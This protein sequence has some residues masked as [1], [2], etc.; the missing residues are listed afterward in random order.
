L[1]LAIGVD[2]G[3]TKIA[4]GAVSNDGAVLSR[5]DVPTPSSD[6]SALDDAICQAVLRVAEGAAVD[7][8]GIGAA[9]WI[10]LESGMIHFSPHIAWRDY[11]VAE[12]VSQRLQVP[13]ILRNDADAAG[14]AEY[15]FGA[16]RGAKVALCVTVGTGIGGGIIIDGEL[17]RGN[18]GL[19]G[20]IGHMVIRQGG[21]KCA[22]GGVGCWETYASGSALVAQAR[23]WMKSK[24]TASGRLVELCGDRAG[25]LTG[26]MITR[27]AN[28]GDALAAE[29]FEWL[30]RRLGTGL[31]SL[32][33][34]L[35]PSVIVVG[36]GVSD[37]G[38]LLLS[39][40]RA[41]FANSMTNAP[42][43]PP[44]VRAE[45]GT[46]AGMVGAADLA[47]RELSGGAQTQRT[48]S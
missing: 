34:V 48:P 12:H 33:A 44:I 37:A 32:A 23:K 35:D 13:V 45:L 39:P 25:D 10:G 26:S 20:E 6:A 2:I 41:S 43:R 8:V 29:L 27:A 16:A 19:A 42:S 11:P 31:G 9:G 15:R 5:H 47:S 14:W 1:G 3:G 28:E 38:E 18:A 7:V 40:A 46:A 21:R 30:G 4:V 22:C 36:G 17:Y 24:P